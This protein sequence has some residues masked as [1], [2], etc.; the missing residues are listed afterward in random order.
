MTNA[1]CLLA[2]ASMNYSA[3]VTI[4][5]HGF[6]LPSN[7]DFFTAKTP[8]RQDAKVDWMSRSLHFSWRSW[9]LGGEF[10][11]IFLS[12]KTLESQRAG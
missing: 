12:V 8:R 11:G 10:G 1:R 2:N 3:V 5:R 9:R 4:L 7:L 6:I